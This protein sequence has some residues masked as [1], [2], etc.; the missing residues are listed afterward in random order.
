[1]QVIIDPEQL[2]KFRGEL[3]EL[4]NNLENALKETD[5]AIEHLAQTW[6]DHGFV[7]FQNKFGEDK[8]EIKPLIVKIREFEG[9]YLRVKQEKA[10]KIR[11]HRC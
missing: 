10:E 8:E 11:D 7:Q 1:M 9:D 2:K 5:H 4:T 3:V 6:K